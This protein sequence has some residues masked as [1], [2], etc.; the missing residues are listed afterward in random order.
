MMTCNNINLFFCSTPYHIFIA[1]LIREQI[2]I[3]S[4]NILIMLTDKYFMSDSIIDKSLWQSVLQ[5]NIKDFCKLNPKSSI[6]RARKN[7]LS[8]PSIHEFDN[9]SVFIGNDSDWRIQIIVR[10][11]NYSSLHLFDEGLASYISN[12]KTLHYMIKSL[13][14]LAFYKLL[15]GRLYYNCKGVG[16]G[17][18]DSY[19]ALHKSCF[20]H[21]QNRQFIKILTFN[22]SKY[23]IYLRDKHHNNLKHYSSLDSLL[24]ISE[25]LSDFGIIPS[26][27]ELI[28]FNNICL[29][30]RKNIKHNT[31]FFKKHPAESDASF[32]SKINVINN[33]FDKD[34]L[35]I[36]NNEVP[37]AELFI[38]CKYPPKIVIGGMSSVL[39][40]IKILYSNINVLSSIKLIDNYPKHKLNGI[41]YIF[42]KVGIEFI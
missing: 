20:P 12:H 34:T 24:I 15:Y 25:P 10:S 36:I 41:V 31:I 18:A 30:I 2:D 8:I 28:S 26:K 9:I 17:E 16:K 35:I 37:I 13:V 1:H 29:Y 33:I 5:F 4:G 14:R 39:F 21:V 40:N 42:D 27:S 6:L 11:L 3:K 38:V 22:S 23:E 19:Y 7:I 32:N